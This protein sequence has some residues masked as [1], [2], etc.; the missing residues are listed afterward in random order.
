MLYRKQTDYDEF[1]CIAD[2]CPKS[3]C[4][5]WQIVIDEDS[6]NKYTVAEG[7]FSDRLKSSID[8]NEQ[9]FKQNNTRC[10]MLNETGLCDLQSTLGEDYLCNTCR[11]FPRHIEEF[12]DIRE[13]SLSLSCPEVT[14]MMMEP[15]F[16]FTISETEDDIEDN[17]D[18]FDDFDF[19]LYDKL[20]Y[21]R[22]KML[23]VAKET[24]LPLQERMNIIACMALKLQ[25]FY[26]EGDIFEMDGVTADDTF[27][28]T[29]TSAMLSLDNCITGFD[30]LIEME[31]LEESWRDSIKE[32]KAFWL[33]NANNFNTWKSAMYPDKNQEFIFEKILESLLYTYFCGAVY[34]GQ[35]YAR[36]MIAVQSTRWLM[37][38]DAAS[39]QGLAKTIYLYSRE[40]EHSDLNINR[41]IEYFESEL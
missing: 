7:N 13:Y 41:L 29:G 30:A 2:K 28:T 11:M 26:D 38:L 23:E 40:V 31:V 4:I 9:C 15:D 37:M 12:L 27:E 24:T 21:A 39:S 17:P 34:D 18:E 10:A 6:I 14:R 32:A 19:M 20:E 25:E 22:D 35:I 36:T 3:C 5:G 16:V 33:N 8:Y 1:K